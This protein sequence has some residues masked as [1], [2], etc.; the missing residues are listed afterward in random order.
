MSAAPLVAAP[1]A[2]ARLGTRQIGGALAYAGLFVG[3]LIGA[4]LAASDLQDSWNSAE[5]AAEVL[6]RFQGRQSPADNAAPSAPPAVIA[7][8]LLEGQTV[9]IAGAALQQRVN[10]AVKAAGGNVLSSQLDL[11]G[12]LAKQG[13]VA[14]TASFDLEQPAVQRLLYDLETGAPYLFVDT[15]AVQLPQGATDAENPRMRVTLGVSG[16][17]QAPK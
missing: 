15:L 14:L 11:L 10:S 8:P 1:F 5:S 7:S 2:P 6:A 9:T 12:P 3:L 4:G 16:Q 17:W 13:Y